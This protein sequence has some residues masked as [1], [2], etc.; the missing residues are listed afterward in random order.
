MYELYK[1]VSNIHITYF[2]LTNGIRERNNIDVYSVGV[3]VDGIF[4][5]IIL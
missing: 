3:N 2:H 4:T 5:Y 1:V